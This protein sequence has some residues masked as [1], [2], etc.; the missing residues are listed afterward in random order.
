MANG[1]YGRDVFSEKLKILK[2]ISST[3]QLVLY[4]VDRSSDAYF[5]A[6]HNQHDLCK[7]LT[8]RRH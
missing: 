3:E 4:K 8:P 5:S 6:P 7:G 1:R 2:L